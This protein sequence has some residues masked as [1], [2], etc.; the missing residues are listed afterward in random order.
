VVR[1]YGDL[2]EG[3]RAEVRLPAPGPSLRRASARRHRAGDGPA[4]LPA[5][6]GGVAAGRDSISE[7][8]EGDG[9]HD[10]RP[11]GRGPGAAAGA[12]HCGDVQAAHL[13]CYIFV[14]TRS[15]MGDDA[16]RD[17]LAAEGDGPRQGMAARE[18][19]ARRCGRV[20]A[21]LSGNRLEELLAHAGATL[22][23][24]PASLP[25]ATVGGWLATRS[26]GLLSARHGSIADMVL[27]LE[28]VNGAGE[29]LRTL[30]GPSGGPDLAQ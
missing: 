16:R 18:L 21:G 22:G 15:V 26:A 3:S 14:A 27:S 10:G 30:E 12:A 25:A 13:I 28:A 11:G 17:G 2:S 23:H 19:R 24:F 5:H 1:R 7:D 4:R 20:G 9:P 6:G 29:I 8:A